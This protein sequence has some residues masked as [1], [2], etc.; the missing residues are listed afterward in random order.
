M[1][2]PEPAV[3]QSLVPPRLNEEHKDLVN[4]LIKPPAASNLPTQDAVY[5]SI[6]EAFDT[7][8]E[9]DLGLL[10]C[11][12][13]ET[14]TAI[15]LEL[16]LSSVMCLRQVNRL[17]RQLV[18]SVPKYCLV[19]KY[20]F[21]FVQH[22]LKGELG[23]WRT[24]SDIE[25]LLRQETCS[26][27]NKFGLK[28]EP[29]NLRKICNFCPRKSQIENPVISRNRAAKALRISS[30][31]LAKLVPVMRG[32][33]SSY[34]DVCYTVT[35]ASIQQLCETI[36]LSRPVELIHG[37]LDAAPTSTLWST[38]LPYVD[39]DRISHW[40]GTCSRRHLYWP[41]HRF[42]DRGFYAHVTHCRYCRSKKLG[43]MEAVYATECE[44]GWILINR[45]E[46]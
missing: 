33:A 38:E 17:A 24:L 9:S 32:F 34:Y 6:T 25:G 45:V 29:L 40:G 20:A 7:A 43:L 2:S 36:N 23:S 1:C 39:N 46:G 18:T 30:H 3:D 41:E 22:T 31:R 11:V 15:I 5:Q 12:P 26:F 16:D 14:L 27:C 21:K 19:S 28:A 35:K 10:Q 37:D 42:S 4:A 44:E 13:V 8:P